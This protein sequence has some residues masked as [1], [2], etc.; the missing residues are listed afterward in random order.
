MNIL[1]VIYFGGDGNGGNVAHA[2]GIIKS[3]A[4]AGN[5]LCVLG[6]GW[7]GHVPQGVRTREVWQWRRPGL[8]T[9][10]FLVAAL[11]KFVWELCRRR[12]DCIYAR[13]FNLVF[14]LAWVARLFRVPLFTE[15][16]AD[17]QAEHKMYGR[18][19]LARAFHDFAERA[20][21]AN[22]LGSIV[23]TDS[24]L[25]S[26][27]NRYGDLGPRVV[28]IRNGVDETVYVPRD[29]AECRRELGLDEAGPYVCY[30]G[31]FGAVQGLRFLLP[32]FKLLLGQY[33][34]AK[35]V[36]VGAAAHELDRFRDEVRG[37][38]LTGNVILIGQ[39]TESVAATYIGAADVCVAPYDR[40]AALRSD[41]YGP[42][43]PMKGDPLKI[44]AYMSCGRAVVASH[45]REAGE[46]LEGIGAGL[47]VAPENVAELHAAMARLL[48]DEQLRLAL[49]ARGR[50]YVEE[51][52]SWN[53]VGRKTLQFMAARLD[54]RLARS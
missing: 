5:R 45:F 18:G 13:Y 15:H 17:L 54:A 47:A 12:P 9:I 41:E 30:V 23:V 28:V 35:L 21:L 31:S 25:E 29:R 1:Y 33:P 50:A 49:G 37:V 32:A 53:V 3:L 8:N 11:P 42:G 48:S 26:W 24:M 51:S 39:V 36:L 14:V 16:N 52:A 6:P 46:Y 27:K 20:L 34:A 40:S 4:S 22:S 19:P 2:R 44:Y 10:S 7:R 38:G 43:A